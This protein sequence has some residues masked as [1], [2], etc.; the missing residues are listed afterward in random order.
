MDTQEVK[1]VS[2][3]LAGSLLTVF[4]PV[5]EGW[6]AALIAITGFM[7]MLIGLTRFRNYLNAK[8]QEA[9]KLLI[10][11]SITGVTG[12]LIAFI[13]NLSVL[14]SIIYLAVFVLKLFGLLRLKESDIST[15]EHGRQGI[16]FLLISTMLIL[17]GILFSLI[18]FIGKAL[19]TIVL[20][21]AVI[22]LITGWAGV[23]QAA[24]T[25]HPN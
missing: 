14:V 18:P 10:I 23:Q 7:F 3:I 8:G 12:M 15:K 4:Y 13:P 20:I 6:S 5:S 16:N 19:T 2:F 11:A 24:A 22:L 17:L 25:R 9:V 21:G 1:S